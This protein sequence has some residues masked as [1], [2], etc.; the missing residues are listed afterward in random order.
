MNLNSRLFHPHDTTYKREKKMLIEE[1]T[2][3]DKNDKIS[4]RNVVVLS[5]HNNNNNNFTTIKV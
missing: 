5:N 4:M 1:D 3:N 2:Y